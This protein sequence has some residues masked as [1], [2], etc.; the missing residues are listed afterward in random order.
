[1]KRLRR[2][3]VAMAIPS[4]GMAAACK[5]GDE[6]GTVYKVIEQDVSS[7]ITAGPQAASP[8]GSPIAS[9]RAVTM[10]TVI[11]VFGHKR[12]SLLLRSDSQ[13]MNFSSGQS[14][15]LRKERDVPHIVTEQGTVLPGIPKMLPA[16]PGNK[17]PGVSARPTQK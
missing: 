12:Y 1:M 2:M 9:P 4:F 6:A 3:L 13:Q 11:F 15:C 7:A 5:P 14:V 16:V 17:K 8:E 10:K